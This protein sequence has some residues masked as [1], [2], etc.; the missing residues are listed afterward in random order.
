MQSSFYNAPS[1]NFVA[2]VP[3]DDA[4]QPDHRAIF[5]L[6]EG[7]LVASNAGGTDVTFPMT[8]G[9]E[10]RIRATKIKETTTGTYA[11]LR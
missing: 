11:L 10:L 4:A 2:A 6:T 9:Q 3:D 1:A 8:A 5:C 7:N